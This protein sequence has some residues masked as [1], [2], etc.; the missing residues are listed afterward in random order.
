VALAHFFNYIAL[1]LDGVRPFLSTDNVH[2]NSICDYKFSGG[3]SGVALSCAVKAVKEADL[4]ERQRC[5]IM[6]PDG[7]RNHLTTFLNDQWIAE[8]GFLPEK[9]LSRQYFWW[10]TTVAYLKLQAPLTIFPEVKIQ[11]AIDIMKKKSFDQMPVV[12]RNG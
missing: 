2:S 5:M 10:D 9:N 1:S 6:L 7:L 11:D 8:R 12:D 3:S 4:K